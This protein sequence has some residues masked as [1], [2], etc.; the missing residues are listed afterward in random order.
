MDLKSEESPTAVVSDVVE[1]SVASLETFKAQ[2]ESLI[3][4][5]PGTCLL[6]SLA[7]GVVLGCLVKR[8]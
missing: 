1:K 7:G 2:A 8:R 5:H 4:R 3:N 6:A